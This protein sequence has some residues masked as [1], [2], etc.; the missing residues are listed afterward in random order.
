MVLNDVYFSDDIKIA[1]E[2][3]VPLTSKRVDF[4]ITGKNSE[5][6]DH[7]MIIELKQWESAARTSR[8][9]IV[10]TYLANE[11]RDIV[12]PSY[13]AYSYVKTIENIK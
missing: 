11:K 10:N 4:L 1:I 8:E 3:Q 2:Y 7:V 5:R 9:D 6:E 13:Q 12:H